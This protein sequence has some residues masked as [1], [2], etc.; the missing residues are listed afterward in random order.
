MGNGS[1]EESAK[2]CWSNTIEKNIARSIYFT[3]YFFFTYFNKKKLCWAKQ[4]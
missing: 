1:V 3:K 2:V 4:Y